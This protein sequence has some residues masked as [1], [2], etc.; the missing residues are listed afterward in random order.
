MNVYY[1]II[2]MRKLD[3]IKLTVLYI[4]YK[5]FFIDILS[6]F[7]NFEKCDVYHYGEILNIDELCLNN[8]LNWDIY[9]IEFFG[10]GRVNWKYL[11]KNRCLQCT[12]E[13]LD[14]YYDCW[15]WNMLSSNEGIFWTEL[16]INKYKSKLNWDLLSLN[17]SLP[18]SI[19]FINRYIDRF[20]WANLSANPSLPWS[21]HLLKYYE[22]LW[23]WNLISSNPSLPWTDDLIIKYIDRL[24]WAGLSMNPSLPWSLE[25]IRKYECNWIWGYSSDWLMTDNIGLCGNSGIHWNEELIE[26]FDDFIDWGELS[27]NTGDMWNECLIDKYLSKLHWEDCWWPSSGMGGLSSNP[28][29]PWSLDFVDKYGPYLNIKE[30]C[31]NVSFP[32]QEE[33]FRNNN[34]KIIND[35]GKS[36]WKLLSMNE[37]LPWSINVLYDNRCWFDWTLIKENAKVYDKCLSVLE[38]EKIKF[39]L[40]LA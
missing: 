4:E 29:L 38:K 11:S 10:R 33:D 35:C 21:D 34:G 16:M 18:W 39:L 17:K 15:E 9:L 13:L 22:D 26:I 28:S 12:V 27:L 32:W 8:A 37:G 31:T 6:R 3:D 36:Y 14:E 25:F 5:N 20:N 23:D 19:D 40:D 24:N 2:V 1:L 7:Y 30:I